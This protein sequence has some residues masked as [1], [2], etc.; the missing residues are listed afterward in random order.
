MIMKKNEILRIWMACTALYFIQ[1][2]LHAQV[3]YDIISCVDGVKSSLSKEDPGWWRTQKDCFE[4]Q[5]IKV[6]KKRRLFSNRKKEIEALIGYSNALE[7][8][9]NVKNKLE[10]D[11]GNGNKKK[12]T[13][14]KKIETLPLN[15]PKYKANHVGNIQPPSISDKVLKEHAN[16]IEQIVKA[17][18]EIQNEADSIVL[19]RNLVALANLEYGIDQMKENSRF[20]SEKSNELSLALQLQFAYQQLTDFEGKIK[21]HF[22]RAY[23]KFV[24]KN[25]RL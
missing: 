17:A 18:L 11:K 23:R 9:I 21:S 4:S 3:G 24:R 14:I 5:A 7:E 19:A 1:M 10:Q 22:K 20:Q 8:I 16:S 12:T 25:K 15:L 6:Q 2:K 13:G